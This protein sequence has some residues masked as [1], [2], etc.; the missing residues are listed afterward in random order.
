MDL[1]GWDER[2]RT[3]ARPHEDLE[4]DPV[5][6]LVRIAGQLTPGKALDLASGAGRNALWLASRGWNVTAVDGSSV[7]MDILRGRAGERKLA[8]ECKVADLEKGQFRITPQSWDLIA[9]C[10]YLQLDLI[11]AAKKGLKPGGT[12]I[13]IVHITERSE[14]ANAHRLRPGELIRRFDGWEILHSYEGEPEDSAHRRAVAEVVARKV[15]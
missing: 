10:Y 15:H 14:E 9:I 6:L 11:E 7:A 1:Q 5:P 13:V 4:A 2:Y 12:I 8:I 3:A